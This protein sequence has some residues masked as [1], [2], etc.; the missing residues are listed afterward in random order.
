MESRESSISC[1]QVWIFYALFPLQYLESFK[2]QQCYLIILEHFCLNYIKDATLG[3]VFWC[4]LCA[5]LELLWVSNLKHADNTVYIHTYGHTY[6][7][8]HTHLTYCVCVHMWMQVHA[9]HNLHVEVRELEF[10]PLHALL[11]TELSYWPRCFGIYYCVI[12]EIST[13]ISRICVYYFMFKI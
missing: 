9:F 13:F 10:S 6:G 12:I 11:F 3:C 4:D 2:S 1:I 7:H 8:T 5:Y